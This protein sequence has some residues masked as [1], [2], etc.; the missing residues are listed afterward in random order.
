MRKVKQVNGYAIYAATTQRDADHYGCNIGSYNVYLSS[1]IRDFG[2]TNSYPEYE[3]IDSLTEALNICRASKYA[4]ACAMADEL[5]NA[6]V[7]DMDLVMEIER[8][9]EAGEAVN[10]IIESYCTEDQCFID[11]DDVVAEIAA[12]TDDQTVEDLPGEKYECFIDEDLRRELIAGIGSESTIAEID[13]YG[14]WGRAVLEVGHA[15]IEVNITHEG[16]RLIAEYFVC[17]QTEEEWVSFGYIDRAAAV[18]FRAPNW[19]EDLRRDMHDALMAVANEHGWDLGKYF[20][21]ADAGFDTALDTAQTDDQITEDLPYGDEPHRYLTVISWEDN[22]KTETCYDFK[23]P[24]EIFGRIDMYDC[25]EEDLS[26]WLM[27]PEGPLPCDWHGTWHDLNDPLK[28]TITLRS[29]GNI[30]DQAWG[31]NH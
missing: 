14:I 17:L 5:T 15:D 28:M 11:A 8:R 30:L 3:D 16:D 21:Y 25:Y 27:T 13:N 12:Q 9:L 23:T 24:G 22:G 26:L 1:D 2:L 7:Q 18:D 4:I 29:T 6:T 20:T 10:E 31:T 19:E